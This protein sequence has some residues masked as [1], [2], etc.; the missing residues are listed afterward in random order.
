MKQ[1]SL[2]LSIVI[3]CLN[4]AETIE[5][6]VKEAK[7][8]LLE[9]GLTGEVIVSDN[10]STDG[11]QQL[12]SA[13]GA[14]VV[15]APLRGYGAALHYGII[16]ARGKYVLFGDADL[17]YDF[18]LTPKF[19]SFIADDNKD[20]VLGSRLNGTIHPG[21]MPFLNR[22]LGTPVLN[23]VIRLFFGLNTSDCNSGMR[24]VR[25]SFYEKLPMRAPGME[26]A[27]ELLIKSKIMNARYAEI[28]IV[29][30][31]DGRNRPPHLRRWRDGWRHLKTIVL[32]SPNRLILLPSVVMIILSLL[33]LTTST[34]QNLGV[35]LFTAGTA[36]LS[37]SMLVKLVLHAD[38]VRKSR[39]VESLVQKPFA[40]ATLATGIILVIFAVLASLFSPFVVAAS[41]LGSA[42]AIGVLTSF[43]WGVLVTH[44]LHTLG[45]KGALEHTSLNDSAIQ[46]ELSTDSI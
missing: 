17:S 43:A 29:L 20:L 28:P 13:L 4:E 7:Q 16:A 33:M 25:K 32:L 34:S 36:G 24:L 2:D 11:S 30:R 45:T 15:P 9:S 42:G 8:G 38:E 27:S 18:T 10:G 1:N 19:S 40:E 22:Y 41:V 6:V 35:I 37:L 12:A 23:W 39:V 46:T 3:P 31:K 21:A 44:C 5:R 14:R 26:W